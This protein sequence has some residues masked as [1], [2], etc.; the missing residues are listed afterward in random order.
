MQLKPMQHVLTPQRLL[1]GSIVL[2]PV[3]KLGIVRNIALRTDFQGV[4]LVALGSS[5]CAAAVLNEL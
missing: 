1:L 3:Q 5:P 2:W 4:E